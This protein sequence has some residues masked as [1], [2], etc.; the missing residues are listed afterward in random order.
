MSEDPETP[1]D[2]NVLG[3]RKGSGPDQ[4]G[5][6]FAG[7]QSGGGAYA[8][9]H[10]PGE[11]SDKPSPGGQSQQG[12]YGGG[13]AGEDGA[14]EYDHHAASVRNSPSDDT[15]KY[16]DHPSQKSGS[17]RADFDKA[18]TRKPGNPDHGPDHAEEAAAPGDLVQGSDGEQVTGKP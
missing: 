16:T 10:I 6:S 12:Y 3:V 2:D 14:A 4:Y 17:D 8:N 13:Q 7:G 9:P 11:K 1:S 5:G 15:G 18:V